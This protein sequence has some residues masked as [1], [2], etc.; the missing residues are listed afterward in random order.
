M[1]IENVV[2]GAGLIVGQSTTNSKH[3]STTETTSYVDL[4]PRTFA[5]FLTSVRGFIADPGRAQPQAL[6]QILQTLESKSTPLAGMMGN[7]GMNA[8]KKF[9][10]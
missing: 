3:H 8:G 10:L 4:E 6:Q 9:R 7:V 1:G 5:Q 2:S